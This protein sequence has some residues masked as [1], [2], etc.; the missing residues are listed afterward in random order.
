MPRSLNGWWLVGAHTAVGV[1]GSADGG[2]SGRRVICSA[3]REKHISPQSCRAVILSPVEV[4]SEQAVNRR[5]TK[6][7]LALGSLR[8]PAAHGPAAPAPRA[9]R[10]PRESGTP[11]LRAL[12]IRLG[13]SGT[14]AILSRRFLE[15]PR[16]FSEVGR[17]IA[18]IG[19]RSSPESGDGPADLA[20][21]SRPPQEAPA[22]DGA[23]AAGTRADPQRSRAGGSRFPRRP[24]CAGSWRRWPVSC[25]PRSE[26]RARALFV[27][28]RLTACS[29]S[30]S[31]GD[32]ITARHYVRQ[33]AFPCGRSRSH[34]AGLAA[35]RGATHTDGSVSADQPPALRG[36]WGEL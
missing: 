32:R 1:S 18:T 25:W 30:T 5:R 12:R 34:A 31:T 26:P 33:C 35:E 21:G 11:R 29:L 36:A 27:L 17:A 14:S 15:R 2:E 4:L 22:Q 24:G 23:G 8:A 19:A 13:T 6:I 9:A 28:R 10:P 7:A 3:H 16:T 20:E